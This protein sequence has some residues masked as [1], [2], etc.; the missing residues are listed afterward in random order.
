[1]WA[2]EDLPKAFWAAIPAGLPAYWHE[3]DFR[4]LFSSLRAKRLYT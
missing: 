1:M 2:N 3:G 4:V